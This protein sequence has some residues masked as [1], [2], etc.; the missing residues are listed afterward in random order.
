MDLIWDIKIA[1]EEQCKN[2]DLINFDFSLHH[3]VKFGG[4]IELLNAIVTSA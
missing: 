1:K 2:S 4:K 3:A